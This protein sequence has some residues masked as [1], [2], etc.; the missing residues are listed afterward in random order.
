VAAIVAFASGVALMLAYGRPDLRRAALAMGILALGI[1]G[2][3]AVGRAS[4]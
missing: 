3:I 1:Y 4:H 2:V